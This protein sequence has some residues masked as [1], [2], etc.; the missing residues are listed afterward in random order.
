MQARTMP[1][2]DVSPVS[3]ATPQYYNRSVVLYRGLTRP[4]KEAGLK[5]GN[6][7]RFV[8]DGSGLALGVGLEERVDGRSSRDARPIRDNNGQGSLMVTIP[9]SA[10]EQFGI[11]DDFD[12][13]T[14]FDSVLVYAGDGLLAFEKVTPRTIDVD[15]DIDLE[16]AGADR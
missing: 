4:L 14:E 12:A 16:L 15:D 1:Q 11:P 6:S 3:I 5:P 13:D 2:I 8:E 7:L 9:S 10:Y